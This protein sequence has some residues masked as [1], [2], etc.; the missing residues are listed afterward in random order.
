MHW[1]WSGGC[2][3]V[4]DFSYKNAHITWLLTWQPL[5]H[6]ADQ[7]CKLLYNPP[8]PQ[9]LLYPVSRCHMLLSYDFVHIGLNG[10]YWPF[11]M[12]LNGSLADAFR[13]LLSYTVCH[14]TTT[15]IRL[16]HRPPPAAMTQ[17]FIR[18]EEMS[19][20]RFISSIYRLWIIN[21]QLILILKNV[22]VWY[23][24]DIQEEVAVVTGC[25]MQSMWI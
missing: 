2:C 6:P 13:L 16:C 1:C 15:V 11:T 18:T 14:A 20:F 24:V 7:L 25:C 21:N 10:R 3:E 5:K 12:N 8:L 23:R 17:C 22:F 9:T 19:D 4:S